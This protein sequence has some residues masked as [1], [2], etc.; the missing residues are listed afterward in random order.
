MIKDEF[1]PASYQTE[2]KT[3]SSQ[4]LFITDWINVGAEWKIPKKV[5]LIIDGKSYFSY[6]NKSAKVNVVTRMSADSAAIEQSSL[7]DWITLVR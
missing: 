2:E 1:L 3:I 6:E 4:S 7:K 5:E